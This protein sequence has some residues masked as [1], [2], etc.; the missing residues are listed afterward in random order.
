VQRRLL[1]L[2]RRRQLRR[3]VRRLLRS[4]GTATDVGDAFR[5]LYA[6]DAPAYQGGVQPD[7][8]DGDF[9]RADGFDNFSDMADFFAKHYGLPFEGQL[10]EWKL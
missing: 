1:S 2:S 7:Q 10:I 5:K 3:R 6:G 4:Q 8:Y 9:V